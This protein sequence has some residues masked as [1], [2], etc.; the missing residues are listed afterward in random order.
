[1][2]PPHVRRRARH[3]SA[4]RLAIESRMPSANPAPPKWTRTPREPSRFSHHPGS[5]RP[6]GAPRRTP[7]ASRSSRR[8]LLRSV[9]GP[10]AYRP[11]SPDIPDDSWCRPANLLHT[12]DGG[13]QQILLPW[14]DDVSRSK[15]NG[16]ACTDHE[17][18]RPRPVLLR[19]TVPG[20]GL[21][22][23]R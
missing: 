16:E 18:D 5:S 13:P 11:S 21:R 3:R 17:D 1:M 19:R 22:G 2:M 12:Q 20:Q 8:S 9:T 4:E 14:N 6:P 7:S 23:S 15:G 10:P